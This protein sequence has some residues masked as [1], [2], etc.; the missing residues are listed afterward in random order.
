[1]ENQKSDYQ[2]MDLLQ[3]KI[4][5]GINKYLENK[6]Y[7]VS[8]NIDIPFKE[9][10]IDSYLNHAPA[11]YGKYIQEKI[12]YDFNVMGLEM[13]PSPT[14]DNKG[15]YK[16]SI[17]TGLIE[18]WFELKS[19]YL[20]KNGGYSIRNIRPYQSINGGYIICF[21]DCLNNF[22]E[23]IYIVDYKFLKDN[24]NMSHMNGTK[25]KHKKNG[26]KNFSATIIKDSIK[27]DL[28]KK[29]SK[30][31][32]NK[33]EDLYK[34]LSDIQNNKMVIKKSPKQKK[35]LFKFSAMG[36]LYDSNIVTTNYVEFIKDLSQIHPYEMFKNSIVKCYISNTDVGM[37]QPNK[38]NDNFYITSYSST[39][40]KIKHIEDLCGFLD[41]NLK[42][43]KET[44]LT[45]VVGKIKKKDT[46]E[47]FENIGGR[48]QEYVLFSVKWIVDPIRIRDHSNYFK[49][50]INYVWYKLDLDENEP[51]KREFVKFMKRDFADQILCHHQGLSR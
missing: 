24:F 6:R 25:D 34:F 18:Y 31:K 2:E 19:S 38:I 49:Q 22:S 8:S 36:K 32:G 11:S 15:D 47:Y 40:R 4:N 45:N 12:M 5:E 21:I 14:K 27:H 50:V 9:F 41:I 26:F 46:M 20:N 35:T 10:L 28:L 51:S 43:I 3:I 30:L 16:M 37:K 29:S 13:K 17:K 23:E 42:R 39:S 44:D 1:M 33:I 48:I 7:V